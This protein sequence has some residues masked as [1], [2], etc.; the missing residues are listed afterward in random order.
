MVSNHGTYIYFG[1]NGLLPSSFRVR[2][3]KGRLFHN[4]LTKYI[5][6]FYIIKL[7]VLIVSYNISFYI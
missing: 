7:M 4:V 6:Y 3:A 1:Y 5:Y 2:Q